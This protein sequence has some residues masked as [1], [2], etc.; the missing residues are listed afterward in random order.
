MKNHTLLLAATLSFFAATARNA[1]ANELIH[2]EPW[3]MHFAEI[4]DVLRLHVPV[5]A[6][7]DTG[8]LVAK[9]SPNQAGA[10]L[11]LLPGDVIVQVDG[12]RVA[13]IRDLPRP[14][15]ATAA[16][17]LRGGQVRMMNQF[18]GPG[19]AFHPLALPPA[20]GPPQ[21]GM[22]AATQGGVSASSFAGGNESVSVS[23]SG[24]QFS[25]EM[26]LPKLSAGPIRLRGSVQE[27][28]QQLSDSKL[29]PAAKQ[30]VLQAINQNR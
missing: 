9:I 23:R 14:T 6:Q 10:R 16:W 7:K 15:A 19:D 3:G 2:H 25:I 1:P 4:P 8:L 12:Q 26:S 11:G 28:Q 27:I 21:F 5:L 17:V 18:M 29:S 30:R 24:D 20:F 22:N 13:T